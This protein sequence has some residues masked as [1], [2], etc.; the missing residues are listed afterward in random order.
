MFFYWFIMIFCII[1]LM[2]PRSRFFKNSFQIIFLNNNFDGLYC[3]NVQVSWKSLLYFIVN[4]YYFTQ[5]SSS[6]VMVSNAFRR[7]LQN[8]LSLVS[9]CVAF[10]HSISCNIC[11]VFSSKGFLWLPLPFSTLLSSSYLFLLISSHSIFSKSLSFVLRKSVL[12]IS[13]E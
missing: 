11:S 3:A 9:C 8:F 13:F 10:F 12:Q 4:S 7:D 5:W 2:S 6:T 1:C